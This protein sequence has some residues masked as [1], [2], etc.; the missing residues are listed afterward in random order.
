MVGQQAHVAVV[1]WVALAPI[2]RSIQPPQLEEVAVKFVE[3][4]HS[5]A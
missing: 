1:K 4:R 5:T 3:Q 2:L